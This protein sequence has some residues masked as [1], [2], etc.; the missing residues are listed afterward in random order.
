M[1]IL[2][3]PWLFLRC[4]CHL[5]CVVFFLFMPGSIMATCFYPQDISGETLYKDYD[6]VSMAFDETY[7]PSPNKQWTAYQYGHSGSGVGPTFQ[8]YCG[9]DYCTNN[10]K[11]VSCKAGEKLIVHKES[12]TDCFLF[13]VLYDYPLAPSN[14]TI[15]PASGLTGQNVPATVGGIN[16][17]N[18][19]NVQI[20]QGTNVINAT[21]IVVVNPTVITCY[22]PLALTT[23]CG[24]WDVVVSNPSGQS[25]T[26]VGV[27][28]ITSSS[29]PIVTPINKTVVANNILSFIALP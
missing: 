10:E 4:A 11:P 9:N 25:G 28:T 8:I 16:F 29:K 19:A 24:A 23:P 18:G 26:G 13:E 12:S 21:N 7:D 6:C 3:S 1:R 20:R 15:S 5:F 2:M 27:F 22:L 17:A 14:I